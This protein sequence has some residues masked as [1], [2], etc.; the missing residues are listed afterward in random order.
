M[1]YGLKPGTLPE[2]MSAVR[3][4]GLPVR[5]GQ[6]AGLSFLFCRDAAER[7]LVDCFARFRE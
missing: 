5:Q 4:I 6:G 7:V 2:Y 3:D 1:I